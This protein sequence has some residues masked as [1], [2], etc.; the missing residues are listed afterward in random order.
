MNLLDLKQKYILK[1][2]LSD[3]SQCTSHNTK[4]KKKQYTDKTVNDLKYIHLY[5]CY[6]NVHCAFDADKAEEKHKQ[7][8][9]S[10]RN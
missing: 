5:I 2:K 7:F 4:E 1:K 3:L 9:S 6:A 10:P 8:L